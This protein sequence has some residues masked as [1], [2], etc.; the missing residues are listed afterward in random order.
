MGKKEPRPEFLSRPPACL[1]PSSV[2]EINSNNS[3]VGN[4]RAMAVEARDLQNRLREQV[5]QLLGENSTFQ[6]L[7]YK[8]CN[9]HRRATYF[10]RLVQIR[11]DFQL[12]QLLGLPELIET[13]IQFVTPEKQA[14]ATAKTGS[15]F[16]RSWGTE[17]KQQDRISVQR[18]LLGTA[19]LLQ[20]MAEPILDASS[21]I[22]GLLSQSFFMPFALTMLALLARFRVLVLQVLYEVIAA[23]NLVA[24]SS[25][26]RQESGSMKGMIPGGEEGH[27]SKETSFLPLW[28][29]CQ[30]DGVKLLLFEKQPPPPPQPS[31]LPPRPQL[32]TTEGFPLS[33]TEWFVDER[34]IASRERSFSGDVA[35]KPVLYLCE[36]NMVLGTPSDEHLSIKDD[37]MADEGRLVSL[38]LSPIESPQSSELEIKSGSKLLGLDLDDTAGLQQAATSEKEITD[39][40]G[41]GRDEQNSGSGGSNQTRTVAY[42]SVEHVLRK[43]SNQSLGRAEGVPSLY[44]QKNVDEGE[45]SGDTKGVETTRQPLD[46]LK[47]SIGSDP[48]DIKV[49]SKLEESDTKKES[50]EGLRSSAPESVVPISNGAVGSHDSFSNQALESGF[51]TKGIQSVDCGLT[52]H[53]QT[54]GSDDLA[55]TPPPC[56]DVPCDEGLE[57][58]IP[59]STQAPEPDAS[60]STQVQEVAST[61]A[62]ESGG[63]ITT[64]SG[65][66]DDA[67]SIQ[68]PI[69]EVSLDSPTKEGELHLSEG[70]IRGEAQDGIQCFEAPQLFDFARAQKESDVIFSSM[71]TVSNEQMTQIMQ[72]STSIEAGSAGH[73]GVK[74]TNVMENLATLVNV[75][76][77]EVDVRCP[78]QEEFNEEMEQVL[79]EIGN[80]ST[81]LRDSEAG[82]AGGLSNVKSQT[83]DAHWLKRFDTKKPIEKSQPSGLDSKGPGLVSARKQ[84]KKAKRKA[85]RLRKAATTEVVSK[86]GNVS[87]ASDDMTFFSLKS[88]LQGPDIVETRVAVQQQEKEVGLNALGSKDE[89]ERDPKR[90]KTDEIFDMLLGKQKMD[91]FF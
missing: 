8:S 82:S 55:N 20:Q 83:L 40:K 86:P 81:E 47:T 11:R 67:I 46:N 72:S 91:N 26:C 59:K 84:S 35:E 85:S 69:S 60:V 16:P 2:V 30:W 13:F 37:V 57:S 4:E 73:S 31:P 79:M 21:Q 75:P 88:E 6:R 28:L 1:E 51:S 77:A 80:P 23:F 5:T 38:A 78:G 9:Q 45:S 12:L 61:E 58:N 32:L 19:R 10:R 49:C 65:G 18:R 53:S 48:I 87:A 29:E 50:K 3:G 41:L 76:A 44:Q 42:I 14:T 71:T 56:F 43:I 68:V 39:S 89:K 74:F 66:L 64:Q 62:L 25:Q 90:L 22:T 17:A 24:A 36:E 63:S 34:S 15:L 33:S 70:G 54:L 7:M 52:V 27:I